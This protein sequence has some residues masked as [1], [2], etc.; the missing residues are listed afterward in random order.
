VTIFILYLIYCFQGLDGV[1]KQEGIKPQQG[2]SNLQQ[3]EGVLQLTGHILMHHVVEDTKT[4]N[5]YYINGYNG[6][7]YMCDR[8]KQEIF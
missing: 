4:G 3:P 7:L 1:V 8:I 5:T 2:V 6:F